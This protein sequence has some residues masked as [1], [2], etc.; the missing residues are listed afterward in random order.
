MRVNDV[1]YVQAD[2]LALHEWGGQQGNEETDEEQVSA[3]AASLRKR[4][5]IAKYLKQL[6]ESLATYDWRSSDAPGLDEDERRLKASFRGSGGYKE[7]RRH[8]LEHVVA[9]RA[10]DV[11]KAAKDVMDSLGY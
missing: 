6:A 4:T 11:S 5:K 8:V 9:C 2:A 10:V 7:L 3:S 1:V